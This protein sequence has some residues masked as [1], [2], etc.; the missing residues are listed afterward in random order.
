MTKL[1]VRL[2]RTTKIN[3]LIEETELFPP[4]SGPQHLLSKII[5]EIVLSSHIVDSY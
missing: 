5:E 2:R 3:L 4:I 1:K